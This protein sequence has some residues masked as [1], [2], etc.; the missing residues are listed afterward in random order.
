MKTSAVLAAVA[1]ALSV[2][3]SAPV[4]A[5]ESE[6]PA[7]AP[8]EQAQGGESSA[9]GLIAPDGW[10]LSLGGEVVLRIRSEA[11][12]MDT[13]S[14]HDRIWERMIPIL[15]MTYIAPSDVTVRRQPGADFANIY[16][17][18]QFLMTVT[19]DTARLNNSASATALAQVWAARLGEVLPQV[20]VKSAPGAE[21]S[22]ASAG[23]KK[24]ARK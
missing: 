6:N 9:G 23:T 10:N 12:G 8:Q 16:V 14:R 22:L 17:K 2:M 24:T 1:A 7:V 4:L 13:R 3:V 19:G 18:D 21:A 5:Q 20:H 11:G 15:S